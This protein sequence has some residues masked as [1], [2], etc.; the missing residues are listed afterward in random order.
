MDDFYSFSFKQTSALV[1]LKNHQYDDLDYYKARN[2]LF[3]LSVMADYDQLVC[4][5]SLTNIDKY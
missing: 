2:Q 3:N 5:P 1:A 4:L